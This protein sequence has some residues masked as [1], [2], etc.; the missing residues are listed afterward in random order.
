MFNLIWPYMFL[1]T[2]K[3]GYFKQLEEEIRIVQN[4]DKAQM[5]RVYMLLLAIIC[6]NVLKIKYFPITKLDWKLK[7]TSSMLKEI[8]YRIVAHFPPV[9]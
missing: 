4:I 1:C 5:I 9:N 8:L 3:V 2:S 6:C 7:H